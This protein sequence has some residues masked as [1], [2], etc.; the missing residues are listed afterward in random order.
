LPEDNRNSDSTQARF[1]F[2]SVLVA[3]AVFGAVAASLAHL[4]RAANGDQAEIGRFVIVTAMSPLL[5]L[6]FASVAF[7]IVN[8]FFR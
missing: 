1:S 3:M 8:R 6:V 2:T 4:W 5:L 7:R